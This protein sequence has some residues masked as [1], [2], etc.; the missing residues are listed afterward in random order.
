M[1]TPNTI[2]HIKELMAEASVFEEALEESFILGGNQSM[3]KIW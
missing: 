2:T 1:L 3:N